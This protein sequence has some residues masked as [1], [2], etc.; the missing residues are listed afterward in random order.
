MAAGIHETNPIG[1]GPKAVEDAYSNLV[2]IKPMDAEVF[3]T[4]V[5]FIVFPFNVH[6]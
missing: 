6:G 3:F 4:P 1:R 2:S 5:L